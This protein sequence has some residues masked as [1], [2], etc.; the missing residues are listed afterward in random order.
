MHMHSKLQKF[1]YHHI[2]VEIEGL[3]L[4]V[5]GHINNSDK[6]HEMVTLDN[7]HTSSEENR[8]SIPSEDAENLKSRH[9]S[10]VGSRWCVS[11]PT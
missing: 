3:S 6:E 1:T 10:P 9:N 8:D 2:V 5:L 7:S 4:L 11:L